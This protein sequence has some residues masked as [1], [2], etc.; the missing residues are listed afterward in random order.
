MRYLILII[1]LAS[2]QTALGTTFKVY[3]NTTGTIEISKIKTDGG[4]AK[5]NSTYLNLLSD[6][7]PK[8]TNEKSAIENKCKE[9]LNEHKDK[10]YK[11]CLVLDDNN[12][13]IKIAEP[14]S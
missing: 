14:A 9:I 5:L 13:V 6:L 1:C 4:T 7:S 8:T 11:D 2:L 12:N 10:K 3:P